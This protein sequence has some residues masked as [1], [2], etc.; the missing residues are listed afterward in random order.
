MAD[1]PAS[2]SASS[3]G[4]SEAELFHRLSQLETTQLGDVMDRLNIVDG[5]I[6][7]IWSNETIVGRAV[8]VLT[9]AGDNKTIHEAVDTLTPGDVLVINGQGATHRALVGDLIALRAKRRGC[10]GFVID[11]AIRDA[12]G[13]EELGFPVYARGVTPAGPYRN[14][15]GRLQVPVA[16]GGV[17]VMPGDY[18]VADSDGIA[19]IP[20]ADAESIVAAAE[21][22]NL[23]EQKQRAEILSAEL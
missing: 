9:A 21:Q 22:K 6:F 19:V 12:Q 13:F 1:L 18:L 11:G 23:A 20:A 3:E 16:I 10:V 2:G 15:P 5:A 17:V 8:T 14:G 4:V 7:P